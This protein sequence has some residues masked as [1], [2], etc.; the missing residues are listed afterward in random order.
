MINFVLGVL[1]VGLGL[2]VSI[3]LHEVGHLVPAKKFGV[4]VTKY[5]VGFG[6]TLWSRKFGETEYGIKAIPFG[7]YVGMIGMYPPA[8]A[9]STTA[10]KPSLFRQMASDARA[11]SDA[12]IPEGQHERTFIKLPVYKRVI[13]MVGGPT[14]NLILGFVFIAIAICGFGVYAPTLT[15]GSVS[16]CVLAATSARQSCQAGDKKAP[17]AAAGI[18]PGDT[19]KTVDGVAVTNWDQLSEILRASANKTLEIE[20]ARNGNTVELEVT[21]SATIRY[22]TDANGKIVTKGGKDLTKTVGF[23]GIGPTSALQQQPLSAV[24]AQVGDYLTSTGN[25]IMHLPERLYNVATST[26]GN[27]K[28]ESDGPVSVVGVG[29]VAG[30][31]A[32]DKRI[33]IA[34]KT[35]T[36]FSILGSLNIALFV[37]NLIPLTPLDGG[38]IAGSLWEGL[39]RT[40]ARLTRGPDPGPFDAA[41]LIPVTIFV[42]AVLI[43]MSLLLIFADLVNPISLTG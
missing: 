21:P 37:F 42:F 2:V 13:V 1:I 41:K 27:S 25:L 35:A 24:P 31:I 18:R 38:H 32:A 22:V 11:Q 12:A 26:F 28:R 29:R 34:D 10:K 5:M 16:E 43:A 23:V 33:S 17:G 14:M 6:K 9:A 39:R 40:W 8:A 19:I 7:G 20:V 3:G 36:M 4:Y 30:E 15:V